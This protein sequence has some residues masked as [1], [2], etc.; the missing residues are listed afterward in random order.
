MELHSNS[1]MYCK[2][3]GAHYQCKG[4][5]DPADRE[6]SKYSPQF[7]IPPPLCNYK[8]PSTSTAGRSW[9]VWRRRRSNQCSMWNTMQ[10]FSA[11]EMR[12]DVWVSGPRPPFEWQGTQAARSSVWPT[13]IPVLLSVQLSASVLPALIPSCS[14][15]GV[16]TELFPQE[17]CV[18]M[19][20][21]SSAFS[22]DVAEQRPSLPGERTPG[23]KCLQ[24]NSGSPFLFFWVI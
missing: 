14:P 17:R 20:T 12:S 2:V 19:Q 22:H 23:H 6:Y 13:S 1:T 7:H 18:L 4:P 11:V 10:N 21:A 5:V 8:E 16:N 24:L 15:G 9:E 3:R